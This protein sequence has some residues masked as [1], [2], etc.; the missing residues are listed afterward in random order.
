M[1]HD[2][3]EATFLLGAASPTQFPA[4]GLPE[5]AMV[6][7]SNVGK[8][9]LINLLLRQGAVA[10][11][12][13]TPGKT[14]E[15]NFFATNLGIVIADLPGYGYASV[16][17]ERRASFASL[18]DA[19][20]G[21]RDA[22]RVT[23]VLIDARHDPMPLDMAMLE[24]LELTGRRFVAVLTKCDKLSKREVEERVDQIRGLLSQCQYVVD[25]VSTSAK[26]SDGRDALI[27]IMKRSREFPEYSL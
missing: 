17:K 13:S 5:V 12:S 24:R 3:I 27:G 10:R 1:A 4:T 20:L 21:K 19:Y 14:Q 2:R 18:I 23:F 16:S 26:T 22:L 8:S 25:V 7:R 9:S 6:G 11:V 15:I